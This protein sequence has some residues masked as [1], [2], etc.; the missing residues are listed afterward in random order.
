MKTLFFVFLVLTL[1]EI[2]MPTA[3]DAAERR[4]CIGGNCGVRTVRQGGCVGG[5]CG[6]RKSRHV[7]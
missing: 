1:M 6:I 5:R 3:A 7:R 4:T 2:E